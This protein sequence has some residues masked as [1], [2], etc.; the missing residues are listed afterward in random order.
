MREKTKWLA[1][2][3]CLVLAGCVES[4]NRGWDFGAEPDPGGGPPMQ[5][6][7][8]GVHEGR[9]GFR[10]R[11]GQV[12][13]FV[14]TW[15]PLDV[16]EGELRPMEMGYRFDVGGET[17]SSVQGLATRRGIEIPAV[18]V[19]EGAADDLLRGLRDD[20]DELAVTLDGATHLISI[21][22]DVENA[23]HAHRHAQEGCQ[24]AGV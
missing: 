5:Q 8:R 9:I 3:A 23:A 2:A 13:L 21:V 19:G 22:F 10:C 14:E 24:G 7:W 1:A 16:P 17:S 18:R 12:M 4:A 6:A 11:D 15:H 20:A